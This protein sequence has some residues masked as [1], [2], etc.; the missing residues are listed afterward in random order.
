MKFSAQKTAPST[1][2]FIGIEDVIDNI[3]VLPGR[4]ACQVIE[5]VATNFSLQSGDEQQVK[6]LSYASLLNSLSFP[7]QITILSRKLDIS[8]YLALLD[9]QSRG[10]GNPNSQNT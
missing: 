5:V 2:A 3:V 7:I 8:S 9:N 10:T 1:Q 6:I 4:Q